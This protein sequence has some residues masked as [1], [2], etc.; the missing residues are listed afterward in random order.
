[1]A[2]NDATAAIKRQQE[3]LQDQLPFDD[4]RDFAAAAR[5]FLGTLSPGAVHD[6]DGNV[7]WDADSYDFITGDAP[8]TV[9]PSLWRQSTLVSKHG[10]FE[11]VEGVYQVRGFDLSNVSFIESDT[12]VIVIDPLISKETAGAALSLYRQHRGERPVVA[13]IFTHSHIDHFGGIFGIVSKG[14]VESGRV[15]II[16]PEG[17]V[18]EAVAEN[19]YAGTAMGRRAGYMYG[20]ARAQCERRARCGTRHDD[21]DRSRRHHSA[22][23]RGRRDWRSSHHRRPR[24]RVPN[25]AGHR[26][27]GRDALPV[28][29]IP[30]AVHGRERHSHPPQPPDPPRS[31]RA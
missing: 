13:V 12:G 30:S 21:I 19:V 9:N 11:V 7:V 16:A 31:S 25:G 14:D 22:D 29:E 4:T 5:G 27:S 23:D 2:Q 15:Q 24:Y 28:P 6:E 17:T 8:H 18:A 10:L 20:A 1:M 26:G 3:A